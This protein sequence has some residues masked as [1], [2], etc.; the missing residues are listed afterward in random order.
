MPELFD[1]LLTQNTKKRAEPDG[2]SGKLAEQMAEKGEDR[3]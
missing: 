3:R 2:N 1:P